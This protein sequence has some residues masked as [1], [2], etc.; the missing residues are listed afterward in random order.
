MKTV[1]TRVEEILK[2]WGTK[3]YSNN[4]YYSLITRLYAEGYETGIGNAVETTAKM[5]LK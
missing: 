2:E 5:I 3:I 4:L 1:E